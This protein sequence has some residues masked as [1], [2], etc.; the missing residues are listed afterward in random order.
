MVLGYHECRSIWENSSEVNNE[1][2]CEHE[3]GNPRDTH[4]VAIKKSVAKECLI[5]GHIPGK[6]SSV[7][8]FYKAWWCNLLHSM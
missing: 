8:K 2:I 3:V 6:F 5:V 7:Y 4:A 1:L